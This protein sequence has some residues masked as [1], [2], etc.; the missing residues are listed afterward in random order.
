LCAVSRICEANVRAHSVRGSVTLIKFICE[1]LILSKHTINIS[2][3]AAAMSL[4]SWGTH[5]ILYT[6]V[7]L[8]I[9]KIIPFLGAISKDLNLLADLSFGLL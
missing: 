2:K 6:V 7:K 8:N 3:R 9:L 5:F 1:T 4:N